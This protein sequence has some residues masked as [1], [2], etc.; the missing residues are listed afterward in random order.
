MWKQRVLERV[1][2]LEGREGLRANQRGDPWT[3]M[4]AVAKDKERRHL[5]RVEEEVGEVGEGA[6][7]VEGEEVGRRGRTERKRSERERGEY[8][9]KN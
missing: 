4:R 7:E 5:G 3:S 1:P 9:V 8:W 2:L 6:K